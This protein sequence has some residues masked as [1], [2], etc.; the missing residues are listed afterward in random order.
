MN[1]A[2]QRLPVSRGPYQL[3]AEVI[4][5]TGVPVVLMHGFPDNTHLYDRLLPDLAGH[6]PVVL[7][8]FLGWGQSDKPAGYPY[9]AAP[10]KSLV[11][12]LV[13][14]LLIGTLIAVVSPGRRAGTMQ[15]RL[16]RRRGPPRPGTP[17]GT[18]R[19]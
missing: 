18:S 5:G 12:A 14:L 19:A 3:H 4:P 11:Y 6:R 2:S 15:A 17:C 16:L 1:L 7:F 8:D 10:V 13:G 9:T